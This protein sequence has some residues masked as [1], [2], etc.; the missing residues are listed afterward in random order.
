MTSKL[1]LLP[2]DVAQNGINTGYWYIKNHIGDLV[3]LPE[4][5]RAYLE[6]GYQQGTDFIVYEG[7]AYVMKKTYICMDENL[8]VYLAI[9]SKD[10]CNVV[11]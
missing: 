10:G 7:I 1:C 5:A 4:E 3:D 2:Y 8:I 11:S 6:A 9:E